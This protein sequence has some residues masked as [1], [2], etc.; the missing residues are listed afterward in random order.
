MD[1]RPSLRRVHFRLWQ[2][3]ASGVTILVTGWC[4]TLSPVIGITATFLAKHVLV[5]I[6]AAGLHLQDDE[7]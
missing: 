5:A 7:R 1:E 6:L 4:F 2:I 3:A